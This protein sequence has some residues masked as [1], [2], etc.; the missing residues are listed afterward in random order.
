MTWQS[1]FWPNSIISYVVIANRQAYPDDGLK[2]IRETRLYQLCIVPFPGI[3]A[4]TV[5]AVS[6]KCFMRAASH[7]KGPFFKRI[8]ELVSGDQSQHMRSVINQHDIAFFAKTSEF[9]DWFRKQ[10]QAFA[11]DHNFR[12]QGPGVI[13]G[14]INIRMIA[15]GSE[16]E[17]LMIFAVFST[18][19]ALWWLIC[20]PLGVVT[21]TTSPGFIKAEDRVIRYGSADRTDVYLAATK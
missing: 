5:R 21:M 13:Y 20:P 19:P 3:A 10:K 18:D 4:K 17:K 8:L 15:V 16:R 6:R 1:I 9:C 11:R 7:N 2:K 14:S 12:I